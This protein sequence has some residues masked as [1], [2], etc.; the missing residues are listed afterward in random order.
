[1]RYYHGLI[2]TQLL[3]SGAHYDMLP[4]VVII[5]ILPYDPFGKNRMIYTIQNQCA[6]DSSLS[7]DDGAKKIFLYTKGTDGCTSQALRDMLKYLEN[8]T[9]TNVTNQDIS[10]IH[11]LVEK[12]KRRKEVSINYMK[13]WEIDEMNREEGRMEG[14]EETLFAFV[15][16]LQEL[17]I[18]RSDTLQKLKEKFSLTTDT[19][20]NY[21]SMYWK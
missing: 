1:M 13:S 9:T 7:Y 11:Q 21:L 6:E 4:S 14:R 5:V 15:T 16:T 10:T 19:A 3:A 17:Q 12:V 20:E 2:D 8:T 18:S